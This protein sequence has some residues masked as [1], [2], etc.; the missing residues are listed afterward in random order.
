MR[1]DLTR[2]CPRCLRNA[3][4]SGDVSRSMKLRLA[5]FGT[6][7]ALFGL[8]LLS[9]ALVARSAP[10]PP[11][12]GKLAYATFAG[13]CF[14][15]MEASMDE[16]PGVVSTTSGYAGGTLKHPTYEQVSAGGTG[17]AESVR[18][19]YDPAKLSYE[20]LLDAFWRNVD[21]TDAGGQFC[22]RGNQY[23]TAIFYENEAER[24]AAEES[25][26]K[27]EASGRLPKPVVT[28]IVPLGTFWPAE[29]YHQDFYK[30]NPIRYHAYRAGCGR[31][32]RL[33]ELWGPPRHAAESATGSRPKGGATD[34][35]KGWEAVKE[36]R[37]TKPSQD[38]L[39]K[40]LTPLQYRVTQQEGTELAFHNEYWNNHEPGI[41]V[42]VLSGEPLF[43]SL[44]KFDS[45]SGWP[46]FTRPLDP[47]NIT[48]GS[49][50]KL[51]MERTE[52]RSKHADSHLGHVFDDG[53]KPTGLRYCINSAALRF[54]PLSKLDAEG[55]GEYKKLFE[56]T[57]S[58]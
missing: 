4:S 10:P 30:K 29:E 53:P 34:A 11:P 21:P 38:E 8:W 43:S 19:G 20:Q 42:D 23:R 58:K 55:Y 12:H 25:K 39:K 28:Q 26:Q 3:G 5:I 15:C 54:V 18:V 27:L 22:D 56:R 14:W 47:A 1:Q 37:W 24:R 17:Y 50:F 48:R 7:L 46:S 49:D 45:G 57:P 9:P 51:G 35:P 6:G 31:D 40:T 36:G 16:V 2:R 41:Y 13:G 44:D 52:V 32:R 33:Q